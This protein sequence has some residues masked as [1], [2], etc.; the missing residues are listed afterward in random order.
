[1][2]WAFISLSVAVPYGKTTLKHTHQTHIVRVSGVCVC[3]SVRVLAVT[4]VNKL[5]IHPVRPF[6][7]RPSCPTFQFLPA[8]SVDTDH[9]GKR[10]LYKTFLH[11]F[12]GGEKASFMHKKKKET[13]WYDRLIYTWKGSPG[14][15]GAGLCRALSLGKV[16]HLLMVLL[17]IRWIGHFIFHDIKY[18]FSLK[19][20]Q[21]RV[22]KWTIWFTLFDLWSH[23]L[24][25]FRRGLPVSPHLHILHALFHTRSTRES[26]SRIV[27]P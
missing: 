9:F 2:D 10:W 6:A 21:N 3:V 8:P 13:C 25:L 12:Q 11:G 27:R 19:K 1:M 23:S 22:N 15:G 5:W 4:A 7:F 18:T 17:K 14:R 20:M 24:C 16:W 26:V